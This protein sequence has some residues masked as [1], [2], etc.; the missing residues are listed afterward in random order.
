MKTREELLRGAVGKLRP[1]SS[2]REKVLAGAGGGKSR[3]PAVRRFALAGA[4]CLMVVAAAIL[5]PNLLN[6][7]V[8]PEENPDAAFAG[9]SS[10]S[11]EGDEGEDSAEE[12]AS[13]ILIGVM[14]EGAYLDAVAVASADPFSGRAS[15]LFVSGSCAVTLEDGS[16]VPIGELYRLGGAALFE[17]AVE[18]LLDISVDGAVVLSYDAL[19]SFIDA[20]DGTSV[21]LLDEEAAFLSEWS[22]AMAETPKSFAAGSCRL[23]GQEAVWLLTFSAD[24]ENQLTSRSGRRV[25]LAESVWA[26]ANTSETPAQLAELFASAL[27][28]TLPEL[29]D[30][31]TL[32]SRLTY[33]FDCI[34]LPDDPMSVETGYDAEGREL[35][36]YDVA[37][38]RERVKE[39]LLSAETEEALSSTYLPQYDGAELSPE[40]RAVAEAFLQIYNERETGEPG[41]VIPAVQTVS[42]EGPDEDGVVSVSAACLLRRCRLD[43]LLLS[44]DD[45]LMAASFRLLAQEDGGYRRISTAGLLTD[46]AEDFERPSA[47]TELTGG[48]AQAASALYELLAERGGADLDAGFAAALASYRTQNGLEDTIAGYQLSPYSSLMT[49]FSP[50]FYDVLTFEEGTQLTIESSEG[51]RF[52][53]DNSEELLSYFEQA[54]YQYIGRYQLFD[55]AQ[56]VSFLLTDP[57]G[58]VDLTLTV[59]NDGFLAADGTHLYAMP[60]FIY[61]SD[62]SVLLSDAYQRALESGTLEQFQP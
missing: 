17:T 53:A 21:F 45:R 9:S 3:R 54:A 11:I 37:E 61:D 43:G 29:P 26:E 51:W 6:L 4:M 58:N 20:E 34:A 48:D 24:G 18:E 31:K 28:S 52:T 56:G 40:D 27:D 39:F 60:E 8:E 55:E 13:S 19:A 10:L 32:A 38:L 16:T 14:N 12:T 15:C 5:L 42:W 7:S 46:S 2:L 1:E 30:E 35:T 62:F 23:S 36:L 57:D 41:V 44:T 25:A 33:R 47:Y 49:A 22:E 50:P 59:S